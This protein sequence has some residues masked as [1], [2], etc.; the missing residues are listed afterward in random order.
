MSKPDSLHYCGLLAKLLLPQTGPGE[1]GRGGGISSRALDSNR[2]PIL[3]ALFALIT[4]DVTS[5]T[6][7][8]AKFHP[9]G[10]FSFRPPAADIFLISRRERALA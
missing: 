10:T 5:R 4:L 1:E 2:L 8:D 3:L 9:T 7:Q 6:P